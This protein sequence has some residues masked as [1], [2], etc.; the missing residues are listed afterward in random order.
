MPKPSVF[1]PKETLLEY[2]S[3]DP[4][5]GLLTRRKTVSNNKAK[6][7]TV[8][9][10]VVKARNGKSYVQIC[11]H[12][13]LIK[14]HNVIFIIMT[15][16]LPIGICDHINGNG[17]DNKWSNLRDTT[18]QDNFKNQRNPVTNTS[19]VMGVSWHKA[20]K[21]WRASITESKKVIHLGVF[22][23]FDAAVIARKE[24]ELE[25]NFHSNHGSDRPL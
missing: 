23:S 8:A 3:Y 20:T 13:K 7:N 5:S 14:A 18:E 21:K 9:G 17:T 22:E 2:F 11:V 24:A 16:S 6:K 15:G 19:G 12:N 1:I 25:L 10:S 4:D